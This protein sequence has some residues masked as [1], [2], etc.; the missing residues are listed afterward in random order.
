MNDAGEASRL[1]LW[2]PG[3]GECGWGGASG[4]KT[5][6]PARISVLQV[7][8]KQEMAWGG[9]RP[10]AG[11]VVVPWAG[12]TRTGELH[13]ARWNP[14]LHSGAGGTDRDVVRSNLVP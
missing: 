8:W 12:G 3:E 5:N 9:W 6:P 10:N 14:Q 11:D 4:V 1:Q 7:L 13:R 2:L